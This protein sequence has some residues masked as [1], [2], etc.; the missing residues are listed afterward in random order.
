[1]SCNSIMQFKYNIIQFKYNILYLVNT[2]DSILSNINIF[3]ILSVTYYAGMSGNI[4]WFATVVVVKPV[5]WNAHRR[6]NLL[7]TLVF[8]INM[9]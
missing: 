4:F 8:L 6:E 3:E 5:E 9:T 2:Y 1:M 7:L